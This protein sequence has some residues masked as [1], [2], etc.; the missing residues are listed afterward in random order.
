MF[1][2]LK[3]E[4]GSASQNS[5]IETPEVVGVYPSPCLNRT[6]IRFFVAWFVPFLLPAPFPPFD[7]CP[8]PFVSSPPNRLW[9]THRVSAG[10]KQACITSAQDISRAEGVS[11]LLSWHCTDATRPGVLDELGLA[12]TTAVFLYAYPTLLTQLKVRHATVSAVRYGTVG[13]RFYPPVVHS[14]EALAA[15]TLGSRSQD[16]S[17]AGRDFSARSPST[18]LDAFFL[19]TCLRGC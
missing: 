3:F 13:L 11:D 16:A 18:S 7:P 12:V 15:S 1:E 2:P 4:D 14:N 17:D 19:P 8:N 9:A 6:R 5:D 10:N